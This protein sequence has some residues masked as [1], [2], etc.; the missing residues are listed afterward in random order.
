MAT[1]ECT[2]VR[3][4]DDAFPG[5]AEVHLTDSDGAVAV[6]TDKAPVFGLRGLTAKSSLPAP[7]EI[8]CEILRRERHQ[9]GRGVVVVVLGHGITDQDG[10]NEF[11]VDAGRVRSESDRPG[12]T[13]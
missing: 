6:L 5:F 11:R 3:W 1:V 10:R 8:D 12:R 9:T 2:L 13:G 7:V 4:V